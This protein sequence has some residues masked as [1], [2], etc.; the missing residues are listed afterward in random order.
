VQARRVRQS[1]RWA[2]AERRFLKE[3]SRCL[4]CGGDALVYAHHILPVERY[5]ELEVDEA[6]LVP[7]CMSPLECL[8]RIGH[9][10]DPTLRCWNPH[11][12]A[13]AEIVRAN[14]GLRAE[15]EKKARSMRRAGL[16]V[17]TGWE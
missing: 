11:V 10:G 1:A 8:I 9:G 16:S 17:L 2:A 6:N 12:V 5:P 3:H 13:D 4:A 15:Y 14:S 7:L